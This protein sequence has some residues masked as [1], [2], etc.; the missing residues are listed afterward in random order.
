[1]SRRREWEYHIPRI[2]W[3]NKQRDPGNRTHQYGPHTRG[4]TQIPSLHNNVGFLSSFM[5]DKLQEA[6]IK[7]DR[8]LACRGLPPIVAQDSRQA[9]Q[10]V[11]R[12][13][14]FL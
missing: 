12:N 1:M 3:S 5:S 13:Q 7:Y 8:L 6:L 9:K 2:L 11:V 10:P 14:S 4:P